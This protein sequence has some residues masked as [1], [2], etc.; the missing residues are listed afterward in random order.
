[1]GVVEELRRRIS[2]SDQR[3]SMDCED[4]FKRS[5]LLSVTSLDNNSD[6]CNLTRKT[7]QRVGF[8]MKKLGK[9]TVVHAKA[10][11]IS[12]ITLNSQQWQADIGVNLKGPKYPERTFTIKPDQSSSR[13]VGEMKIEIWETHSKMKHRVAHDDIPF[14]PDSTLIGT[15]EAEFNIP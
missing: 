6:D 10:K 14:E 15:L 8:S 9:S 12:G 1:M 3:P 13:D 4:E 2:G 11:P 5:G 7:D